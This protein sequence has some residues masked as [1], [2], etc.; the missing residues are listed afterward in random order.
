MEKFKEAD[1]LESLLEDLIKSY[2]EVGKVF[3]HERDIYL[4]YSL[5]L[6]AEYPF[7]NDKGTFIIRTFTSF[8]LP[9][10]KIVYGNSILLILSLFS[11]CGIY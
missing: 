10:L 6:A 7:C 8:Y 5:Q 9:N 2:P 11:F 4:T 1:L 3:V